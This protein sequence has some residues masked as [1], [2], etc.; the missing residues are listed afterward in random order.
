[1]M[2]LS[3]SLGDEFIDSIELNDD[4]HCLDNSEP[5]TGVSLDLSGGITD[6]EIILL[7]IWQEVLGHCEISI[8]CHFVDLG[9][10]GL[11]AAKMLVMIQKHFNLPAL[12]PK[13]IYQEGSIKK[14]GQLID[15]KCRQKNED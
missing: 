7:K 1:M 4:I 9:G 8:H 3:T 14:L 15:M 6:I 12:S 5:L 10:K 13:D 2:K 11:D